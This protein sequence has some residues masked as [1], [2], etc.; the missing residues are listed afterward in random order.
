M[1]ERKVNRFVED[2]YPE[3]DA[4][5]KSSSNTRRAFLSEAINNM[6]MSKEVQLVTSQDFTI[7]YASDS[8]VWL[9]N[10][11]PQQAEEANLLQWVA[12]NYRELFEEMVKD[13]RTCLNKPVEMRDVLIDVNG[14]AHYFDIHVQRPTTDS[15]EDML[16]VLMQQVDERQHLEEQLDK[17]RY[18]L[19][20]L[21][22]KASH[23]LRSPLRTMLGLINLSEID[24]N[25]DS[26]ECMSLIRAT[27]MELDK[28]IDDMANISLNQQLAVRTEKIEFT[29]MIHEILS[30]LEKYM[31]ASAK[32][33]LRLDVE[34]GMPLYSDPVR[35]NLILSNLLSNAYQFYDTDKAYNYVQVK[36]SSVGN[37]C[38]ISISD[39]GVGIPE[40][41]QPFIFDM[42]FRASDYS[43]G[44]G[45]GLYMV[46][47]ALNKLEG[48]I[49][50]RSIPGEGSTFTIDIPNRLCN[51]Q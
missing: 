25:W 49:S 27:I 41:H 30:Y 12:P 50:V 51:L 40:K 2:G 45:L 20:Y 32:V 5:A 16:L 28:F 34:E 33:Q 24:P 4:T 36:V 10:T 22:Y 6:Q 38:S 29:S 17:T 7:E 15:R 26:G 48:D 31:D 1:T 9:L 8:I 35:L 37:T 21:I 11:T 3:K 44:C 19:D 42:F 47:D 23:D 13:P 39:N 46:K 43:R 18:E 14:A